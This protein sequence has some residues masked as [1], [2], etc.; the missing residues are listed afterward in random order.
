M[1][2]GTILRVDL[3]TG[4]VTKEPTAQYD[5]LWMGGRGFNARI[6]YE[7]VGPEV[8]PFDPENIIMFSVG[9]FTGTMVPGSGR[10]EI[11]AKSPTTGLQGMSNMGGFWGPELK[12]A[13]YDSLIIMGKAPK[14]VY[15]AIDNDDVQI[16]D[17]LHLWGKDT[18]ETPVAIRADLGDPDTEVACI[19]RAGENQVVYATIQNRLGNAAGRTG[20]GAVMGSK[21]LKAIAVRGTK[22]VSIAEP[23]RFLELCMDAFEVQK[24]FLANPQTVQAVG[25]DPPSWALVLGN[26]EATEWEEQKSLRG[27]HEPFWKEH[28]NRLG[29]G[30]IGCFNCQIRCSDYYDLPEFGTLVASCNV[31][32]STMWVL[33]DPDFKS[34]YAFSTTCQREG[35]DAMTVS[36]MLAWAME[37]REKGK[38][39]NKDTDG[40]PLDWGNGEAI[41]RMVEK[42]A[43]R[44]GFGDVLASTVHEARDRI[45]R[46][47]DE[48]LNIKGAPLGGTNLVNWRPRGLAAAIS[49]RGGDEYRTRY[50]S[51]DYLGGKRSGMTG[52][53][54]PDSWEAK[55]AMSI[56]KKASAKGEEQDE[57]SGIT[58]F[59][60]KARGG[61]AA[62]AHKMVA[63]SDMLGQCRWNTIFLNAG[64][65]IEFQANAMSAGE[66]RKTTIDDLLEAGSRVAAQERAFAVREGVTRADDT[67]PKQLFNLQMPGTW[68]EDK[69][70]PEEFE[71]MK[72]EYYE[73][74]GWDV[75]T[76]APTS[77]TLE[78]LEL[79]DVA[80]ELERLDKLPKGET[81]DKS[82][83][84]LNERKKKRPDRTTRS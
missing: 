77:M 64:I 28:K 46:D 83:K 59:D 53:S 2:G 5:R 42:I 1:R 55:A 31:Y 26:Y 50:G 44:E 19:G 84:G 17:A 20:M 9:P 80:A 78:S 66:G 65:S 7:D 10:T 71:Q 49:P 29:D 18:Y 27:G 15:L 56:I 51:F 69:M 13:G 11:A 75:K 22:G 45:G 39:T 81:Y 35:I 54:S 8:N 57:D 61:L 68:P 48:A 41:I 30:K 63:V 3:T 32:A 43:R 67:L 14:P 25:N 6:L 58:Q 21:N 70:D 40:I 24:P 52:M 76:G 60:Y 47:V 34:W 12:W 38:I 82:T 74:M 4:S 36:R 79:S 37:L 73:A 62:L 16:R 23:E 33:K 72:D